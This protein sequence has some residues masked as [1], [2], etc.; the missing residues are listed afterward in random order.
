MFYGQTRL[1]REVELIEREIKQGN[2]LNLL[3]A[4]PSG[5]GKTTLALKIIKDTFGIDNSSFGNS[6]DFWVKV[7]KPINFLDEIH[8]LE[9]PE[10]LYPYLDWGGTNFIL[11]TNELGELKEP[12]VRR[13]IPLVFDP[14]TIDDITNIV[15]DILSGFGPE[16][17]VCT[18]IAE[19]CKLSPGITKVL[20]QR[21]SYIFRNVYIPKNATELDDLTDSIL[22]I[23]KNGLDAVDRRYLDFLASAG[24]KASLDLI[25]NSLHLNRSTILRDVEPQL[26]YLG[27]IKI[28]SKGRELVNGRR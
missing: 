24:N 20:C 3:L 17:E 1:L 4:A 8:M 10:R 21:I 25:S 9:T 7:E 5:W 28:T 11:A 6:P 27:Y 26:I 19:K 15:S 2:K 12:L 14:Y 22:A 13:C 23:D 16:P 18:A